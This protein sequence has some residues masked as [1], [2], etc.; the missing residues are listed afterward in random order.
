[1]TSYKICLVG[2]GNI[3][4]VRM[5]MPPL[6]YSKVGS[7]QLPLTCLGSLSSRNIEFQNISDVR[8]LVELKIINQ[9]TEERNIFWL[10]TMPESDNMVV[11]KNYGLYIYFE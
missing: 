6:K 10:T 9:P 5:L 4:R 11:F 2:T 8:S 3:P 7:I 1:M